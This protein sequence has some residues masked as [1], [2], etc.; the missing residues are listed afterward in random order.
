MF[1]GLGV[2]V[3]TGGRLMAEGPTDN[4]VRAFYGSFLKANKVTE[5]PS[6]DQI[7][8]LYAVRGLSDYFTAVADGRCV[9]QPDGNWEWLSGRSE[10]SHQYLA[11]RM[12]QP[13]LAAVIES[14][15][16]TLPC[17]GSP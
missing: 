6:W 10:K 2:D 9:V 16:L 5:R 1:T 14:L 12:P 11:Y 4:P 8:V 17:T 15:M 3:M 13:E 7:A